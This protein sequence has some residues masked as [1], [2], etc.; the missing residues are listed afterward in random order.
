MTA[1]DEYWEALDRLTNNTPIRLPKGTPI[2][3]DSVALEAGRGR[4]SIKKSRN[5]F[6]ALIE[7]IKTAD[8]ANT[9]KKVDVKIQLENEKSKK[10]NYRELYHLSLNREIMLLERL[11][12]LEKRLKQISNITPIFKGKQ[13][14]DSKRN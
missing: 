3:N 7:A 6:S 12:Q 1:I 5:A 14:V 9:S 11:D 10:E 13:N 2:N 4:G 8:T